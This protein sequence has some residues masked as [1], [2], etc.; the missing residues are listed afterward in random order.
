M[1]TAI[2]KM[3]ITKYRKDKTIELWKVLENLIEDKSYCRDCNE[4]IFYPNSLIRLGK[5]GNVKYETNKKNLKQ[6]IQN[7]KKRLGFKPEEG[8]NQWSRS[9]Q[10]SGNDKKRRPTQTLIGNISQ[11]LSKGYSLNKKT[12]EYRNFIGDNISTMLD[13]GFKYYNEII[14]VNAIGTAPIRANNSMRNRKVVKVHQNVLVFYKGDLNIINN[15]FKNQLY[16]DEE[17]FS[18]FTTTEPENGGS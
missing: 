13:I 14:L 1:E 7:D 6:M 12:G 17:L 10:N 8:Q 5:D 16:N 18:E 2:I 9:C 11:L 15:T 4:S 3:L